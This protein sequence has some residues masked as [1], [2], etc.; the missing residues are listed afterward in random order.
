MGH[1]KVL[2]DKTKEVVIKESAI[3]TSLDVIPEIL[4]H[5]VDTVKRFLKDPS[6]RKKESDAV[7][8]KSVT[9]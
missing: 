9:D 6:P 5:H 8:F 4:G 1:G 2:I 3:G 7:L